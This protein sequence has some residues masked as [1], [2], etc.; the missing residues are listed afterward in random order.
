MVDVR[1]NDGTPTGDFIPHEL[2]RD[3]IRNFRAERLP[4]MLEIKP[5]AWSIAFRDC[6]E[7]RLAPE[8]FTN[9]DVFHLRGDNALLRVIHLGDSMT[10][11]RLKRLPLQARILLELVAGLFFLVVAGSMLVREVTIVLRLH[12]ASVVFRDIATGEDP[13]ATQRRKAFSD[14]AGKSRIAP[15]T[16]RVIDSN[17]LVDFDASV[18]VLCLGKVDF[19]KGDLHI[20][21]NF[22]GNVNTT[23]V[24]K[25]VGDRFRLRGGGFVRSDH[26]GGFSEKRWSKKEKTALGNRSGRSRDRERS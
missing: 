17:R 21:V 3:V 26:E 4:G 19:A 10:L 18:R 22:A 8:V 11:R 12:V 13:V 25:N 15:G 24:W 9:R 5:V 14:E 20:L 7:G 2:R 6:F 16:A 23:A 1:R